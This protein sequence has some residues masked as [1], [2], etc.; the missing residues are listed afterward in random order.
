[1]ARNLTHADLRKRVK[2]LGSDPA[3][4][5]LKKVVSTFVR[6][7]RQEEAEEKKM[8]KA[9]KSASKKAAPKKRAKRK[10][11]PAQLAALA[12]GR[13]KSAAKRA[14]KKSASKKASPKKRTAR[15]AAP[16]K[17]AARKAA[18]K[19]AAPKKRARKAAPKKRAA[20]KSPAKT[21]SKKAAPKRRRAAR[22]PGRPLIGVPPH[23]P[24][25][26]GKSCVKCGRAHTL[27]EHWSHKLLHGNAETQRS[28]L[29]SR[30]GFCEFKAVGKAGRGRKSQITKLSEAVQA[31]SLTARNLKE[32]MKLQKLQEKLEQLARRR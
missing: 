14:A 4:D 22:R 7:L 12:K 16:K 13:A 21:Y 18:P 28:Y 2:A 6:H 19:K 30:G 15:K 9:K 20:R 24:G 8:A 27:R 29:C 3:K 32:Q 17:R 25:R 1:M 26:P 23:A 11:T 31:G 10:A 5:D